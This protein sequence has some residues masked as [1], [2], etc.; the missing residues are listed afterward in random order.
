[1]QTGGAGV[2]SLID[3]EVRRPVTRSTIPI[4]QDGY[5]FLLH[6]ALF[7]EPMHLAIFLLGK[8]QSRSVS[9]RRSF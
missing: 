1:M 2:W 3:D 5:P 4:K 7:G 6:R 9:S 8:I